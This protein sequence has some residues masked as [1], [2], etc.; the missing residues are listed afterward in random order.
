MQDVSTPAASVLLPPQPHPLLLCGGRSSLTPL[1]H[2]STPLLYPTP[3]PLSDPLTLSCDALPQLTAVLNTEGLPPSLHHYLPLYLEL[4]FESALLRNG[5]TLYVQHVYPNCAYTLLQLKFILPFLDPSLPTYWPQRLFPMRRWSRN[6][7][8][9]QS[10]RRPVWDM[11]ESGSP[12][13]SSPRL[14]SSHSRWAI[15]RAV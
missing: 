11:V 9:I 13:E 15:I 10:T 14:S 7:R 8:E 1:P 4:I 2:S 3:L 6:W 12:A 5:G